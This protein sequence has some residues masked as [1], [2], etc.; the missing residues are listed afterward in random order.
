MTD[1]QRHSVLVVDD[2]EDV[3]EVI[4]AILSDE[5]YAVHILSDVSDESFRTAIGQLEPDLILLDGA[6]RSEYGEGWL[7]AARVHLRQRPIPVVMLT[8]MPPAARGR[9]SSTR[10]WPR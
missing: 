1:A 9:D 8:G 5:G 6:G 2:D 10:C 7:E 3:G 4:A